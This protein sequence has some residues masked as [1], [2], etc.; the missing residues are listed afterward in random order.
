M[1]KMIVEVEDIFLRLANSGDILEARVTLESFQRGLAGM[2]VRLGEGRRE[3]E[4]GGMEG[5]REG[6]REGGT[7]G[8]EGGKERGRL[9]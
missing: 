4:D 2:G 7:R 3:E 9:V 1:S 6:R 8:V 5:W